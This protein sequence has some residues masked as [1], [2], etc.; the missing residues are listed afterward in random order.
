MKKTIFVVRID[1]YLPEMCAITLPTIKD[2]AHRIGAEYIEIT[3]R[4]FPKYP[5]PY[6]KMQIYKLGKGNDWNILIDADY[7]IHPQAPDFT[8]GL[9]DGYVGFFEAYDIRIVLSG[10]EKVFKNDGRFIGIANNFTI[11][12]RKTHKLWQP[13]NESWKDIRKKLKREFIVD[14]YCVSRNLSKYNLKFTGLHY[15]PA[16]SVMFRH[17]DVTTSKV[18][19]EDIV[20]LAARIR[21]GFLCRR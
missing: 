5:I 17:L 10:V 16:I 15:D 14:E 2:Y 9:N 12:S 19:K 3:E 21:E 18:A 1:D 7:M 13:L 6:E 20:P 4:K 11:T 8:T